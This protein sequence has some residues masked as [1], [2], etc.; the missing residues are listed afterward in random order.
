MQIVVNVC[1]MKAPVCRDKGGKFFNSESS[2]WVMRVC[3]VTIR[4]CFK[5]TAGASSFSGAFHNTFR[6]EPQNAADRN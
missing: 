3:G 6:E 2:I 5:H 1:D 4:G